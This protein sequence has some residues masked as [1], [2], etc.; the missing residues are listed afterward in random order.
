ME[1]PP[2]PPIHYP[3]GPVFGQQRRDRAADAAAAAGD[4][5]HAAVE[6][7]LLHRLASPSASARTAAPRRPPARTAT[8][9]SSPRTAG[10]QPRDVLPPAPPHSPAPLDHR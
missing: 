5:R 7:T 9:I 10:P 8:L 6:G 2:I 4:D 3:V 1:P